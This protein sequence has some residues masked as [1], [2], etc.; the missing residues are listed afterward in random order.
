MKKKGIVAKR[1]LANAPWRYDS[2]PHGEYCQEYWKRMQAMKLQELKPAS[3]DWAELALRFTLSTPEISTAIVG[4][5]NIE[6]IKKNV[7]YAG[8]GPLPS[9]LT[10]KIR[11]RFKEKDQNWLGEV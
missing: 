3:M 7:A 2:E 9:S 1:P 10:E 8:K 6:N 4:S 5:L 11:R